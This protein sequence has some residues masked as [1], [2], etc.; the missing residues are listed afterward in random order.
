MG[1]SGDE[2]GEVGIDRPTARLADLEAG[3]QQCL[4]GGRTEH[5]E[6]LRSDN[7]ELGAQPWVACADLPSAGLL[8]DAPLPTLLELEVLHCVC[9]VRVVACDTD[10][11]QCTVEFL[12]GWADE[13]AAGTVFLI[14]RDLA[15][16]HQPRAARALAEHRLRGAL[17][18]GASATVG[19]CR[20]QRA[21][22]ATSRKVRRRVENVVVAYVGASDRIVTARSALPAGASAHARACVQALASSA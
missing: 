21:E 15:D 1:G 7:V 13:D 17:V 11:L 9:H 6:R 19:R 3:A 5:D 2:V 12:S 8:M 18:Q 10:R 16:E 14:A 22:R 4:T 20:A